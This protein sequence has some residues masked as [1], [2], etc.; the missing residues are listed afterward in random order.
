MENFDGGGIIEETPAFCYLGDLRDA[1][2]SPSV[3]RFHCACI[4][5]MCKFERKEWV[6]TCCINSRRM[7]TGVWILF[8]IS[9]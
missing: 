6:N 3:P 8:S 4:Y 7:V 9:H 5:C 1:F 2:Y